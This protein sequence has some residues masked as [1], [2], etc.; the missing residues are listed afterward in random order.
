MG[1]FGLG[2]DGAS[3]LS[4]LDKLQPKTVYTYMASPGAFKDYPKRARKQNDVL[5]NQLSDANLN[6]PLENVERVFS[7]LAELAL[8]H[9]AKADITIVPMGPKPH[10]LAAILLCM[11]FQ[12]IVCLRVSGTR[13]EV[14]RVGTTGKLVASRIVFEKKE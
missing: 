12:E 13:E 8:P 7:Y 10:V 4:V 2:F 6:L 1:I 11:R 3:T 14:E 9:R 5:I